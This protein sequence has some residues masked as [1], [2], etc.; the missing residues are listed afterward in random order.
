MLNFRHI[1]RKRLKVQRL[2]RKV[3][4]DQ[5]KKLMIKGNSP[6]LGII[7]NLFYKD[8]VDYNHFLN[9]NVLCRNRW[10]S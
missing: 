9:E 2:V 10:V 7:W 1:W 3:P 5:I 6:F 8:K 4:D